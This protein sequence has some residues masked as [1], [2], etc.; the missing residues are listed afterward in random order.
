MP[1]YHKQQRLTRMLRIPLHGK[2]DLTYRCNNACRHC[3]LWLAENAAERAA[4]LTFEEIRRI[5][6]QARSL[7][8]RE[9]S[10][11]GGE[12]LLRDDFS[13]IFDYLTRKATTY[14]LNTNGTLITPA[15]AQLLTRKGNKMIALYGATEST[16]DRVTRHE[17]GF[18]KA[19]RG[20]RYLQ[21]AGAGFTVQLIPMR[22]NWH[23]WEQMQALAKSL[24]RHWR[25]GAAW[26][27]K[28][29][30]GNPARNAE[31]ERQ[32]L[33]PRTVIELDKPDMSGDLS[34]RVEPSDSG[35]GIAEIAATHRP[36]LSMTK[37]DDRLFACC[38]A[39]RRDFHMDPYGGMTFCSFLKDPAM[40]YDVRR[41]TFKEAWDTFVPSLADTVRGGAEYAAHCGVCDL[42]ADCRWCA[43]YGYLETGRYAAPVPYLCEVARENR[44]FKEE[45]E[46]N[47]RRYY[48]IGG[49]TIQ[50]DSDLPI[51]G[52]TFNKA[53]ELFRVEGP[54]ED[55][56]TIR[57][58]FEL[59]DLRGWNLGKERY[60]KAPWAIYQ[61]GNAWIYLGISPRADDPT[62]HKVA[63][64]NHDHSRARIYND[65]DA[66]YLKG[67]L[68]SLT[69]FPS[70]QILVARLLADRNGCYLHSAGAVL[71]G[72]GMLFVG[73]SEAGKSTI[74][75]LLMAHLGV[76]ANE[77]KQSPAGSGEILCDDR[78]IVR[79][80]RGGWRVYGTW[81]HGDVPVVSP[82]SA[83]LR[84]I[85][86]IEKAD[87]NSLT[88]L[89]DR[90][91]IV[92]RLLACA[93]KPFVTADWW[94][95]TLS[96][97]ENMAREVP[98]YV[99]RFDKSGEIVGEVRKLTS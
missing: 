56:V 25:V 26:L 98:C 35:D 80:A 33:D 24:S 19:M 71:D 51:T 32:R 62:L 85:C 34:L 37:S 52:T 45:W 96:L 79:R 78:N 13:D 30:C 39:G 46:M 11:S 58:Y 93:I 73:H 75:R 16:Y 6:D 8:C 84:A 82:A 87:E 97:I 2:I 65:R 64:F 42:R 22:D 86:F 43:V 61:Q 59:P 76:I 60:R 21:E 66:T 55:M 88:P 14:S 27:Y 7:G 18:E 63:T 3:W 48:Q 4:E 67:D 74:T 36:L 15:I 95:K 29:A 91:E 90:K 9:W 89:T 10:I 40:R 92:R 41:G 47:H 53:L 28:S 31:I 72:A 49:I 44:K 70:D 50:V 81:H 77:A 54:G 99:M 69:M 17:G 83:P 12:P 23:E 1:E 94:Q 5:A 38:V 20:F 68:H 57:H